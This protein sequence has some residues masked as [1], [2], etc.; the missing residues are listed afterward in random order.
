MNYNAVASPPLLEAEGMTINENKQI[1]QDNGAEHL[2][3]LA[4]TVCSRR[5]AA[6]ASLPSP[7]MR[8]TWIA[9][10]CMSLQDGEDSQGRICQRLTQVK[11]QL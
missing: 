3:P 5:G 10:L 4:T 8:T 9:P 7:R 6:S 1:E 2:P 11:A